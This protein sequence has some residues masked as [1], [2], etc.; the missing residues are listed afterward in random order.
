MTQEL[1]TRKQMENAV[2]LA[3]DLYQRIYNETSI[4]GDALTVAGMFIDEACK[5]EDWLTKKYGEDD[6]EY[7]DRLEEYEAMMEQEYDLPHRKQIYT[8]S[9]VGLSDSED[10]AN[11]YCETYVYRSQE[12]AEAKMKALRDN[13][14][15]NCKAEG[16]DYEILEDEGMRFRMSWCGGTEQVR[17]T[18]M[19]DYMSD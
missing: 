5:M 14:I 18:I 7:L 12:K 11:G 10:D 4:G 16:H 1:F 15:E 6:E 13:E 8:V 2:M 9:Y 3:A 19:D 17:I